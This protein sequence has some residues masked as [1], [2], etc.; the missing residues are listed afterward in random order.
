[1]KKILILICLVIVSG[2]ASVLSGK[3]QH[4]HLITDNGEEVTAMVTTN[5][6]T[7]EMTLPATLYTRK[8]KKD[9]IVKID[10]NTCH[11]KSYQTI[12]SKVNPVTRLNFIG[13]LGCWVNFIIDFSTGAAWE[14]NETE[15]I[16]VK[17]KE[18]C[19]SD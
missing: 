4:I 17:E 11:E 9:I 8:T 2:C 10:E 15:T 3:N 7:Q 6:R 18:S 14:Y 13:G 19:K 5:G 12:S 1:M 16:H